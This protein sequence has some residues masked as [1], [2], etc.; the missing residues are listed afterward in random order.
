MGVLLKK[1]KNSPNVLSRR[2]FIPI[3]FFS[4]TKIEGS[5]I[6][7]TAN[8]FLTKKK[9]LNKYRNFFLTWKKICIKVKYP[10]IRV[11]IRVG[12]SVS[13]VYRALPERG[14]RFYI[15]TRVALGV[16]ERAHQTQ[17]HIFRTFSSVC[18]LPL[19]LPIY[20]SLNEQKSPLSTVYYS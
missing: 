18:I 6:E 2:F 4:G 10:C 15:Y 1:K 17:T 12:Y 3:A 8:P 11:N 19:S 13:M 20:T 7:E 14:H 5:Q 9:T 16:N